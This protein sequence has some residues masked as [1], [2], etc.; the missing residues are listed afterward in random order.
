MESKEVL[1]EIR[2]ERRTYIWE[3]PMQKMTR[4]DKEFET[5]EQGGLSHA[6]F[7]ALWEIK[8]QVMEE[9]QMDMP[10]EQTLYRK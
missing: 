9:N 3:T 6:G 1:A 5:L 8:P 10:T 4:L 7:R 2:K